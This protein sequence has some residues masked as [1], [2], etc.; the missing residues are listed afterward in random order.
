MTS[1]KSRMLNKSFASFLS[2]AVVWTLG[3]S[4]I[5][6]AQSRGGTID[7]GTTIAVRTNEAIDAKDSDGRVFSGEVAEDVMD[8][9]GRV[10]VPKGSKV[11]MVVRKA[12]DNENELVL[13]LDSVM[14]NGQRY[15]VESESSSVSAG[16]EGIGKN[17][18][19]GKYVGGGAAIGAIIGAIAGGG[20]GAAIGAG[21]GAA[22]GAGAQVLT[23]G[24]NI[25]VPPESL[26][27]FRLTEP[28]RAG[29]R[30]SGFTRDGVH[31]HN[32]R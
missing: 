9:A 7:A 1:I 5:A 18:R 27:T 4:G 17:K 6:G 26:V 30:D 11:E 14:V 3:F 24:H 23:R 29:V 15:S 21:A 22:A 20:K 2:L 13:D 31:H 19:T 16:K 28:L 12:A 25:E 10:A 8:R 32:H